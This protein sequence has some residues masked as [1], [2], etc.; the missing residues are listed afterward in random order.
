MAV[1]TVKGG[2]APPVRVGTCGPAADVVAR[3]RMRWYP[4]TLVALEVT[5]WLAWRGIVV[6]R[7]SGDAGRAID[8]ARGQLIGPAV[9]GFLVLV[10]AAEWIWPAV[11]RPVLARRGYLQD[12]LYLILYAT[13]VV[14]SLSSSVSGSPTRCDMSHR[15]SCCRR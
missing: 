8:S 14:P 3:Q 6:L 11:R 15:G 10:T 7:H 2:P 9:L 5:A 1:G 13:A 12:S 4:P